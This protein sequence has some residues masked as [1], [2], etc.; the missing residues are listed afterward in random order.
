MT[1]SF[2]PTNIARCT[3]RRSAIRGHAT[4]PPGMSKKT[5]LTAATPADNLLCRKVPAPM[6]TT[7]RLTITAL[8]DAWEF[9]FAYDERIVEAIRNLS[10]RRYLPDRRVWIVPR[11]AYSSRDLREHFRFAACRIAEPI[12]PPDLDL[13]RQSQEFIRCLRRQR[14]SENT[15]RNY[16]HQIDMFVSFVPAGEDPFQKPWI[17][18]YMHHLATVTGYSPSSQNVAINAIRLHMV[19]VLGRQMPILHIRPRRVRTLPTVLGMEEVRDILASNN[20]LKHQTVL[21]LIYSGG[22]RVSEAIDLRQRDID[23]DRNV[24]IIRQSKGNKDRQ[25]PL[26]HHLKDLIGQYLQVYRPQTFLFEG[27]TGGQYTTKSIQKLF[28][29]ACEKAGLQK[30]ASIHTL[31]HSYA[32]HLLEGGTDLRIIQAIL[33]HTSSKTTEIYTHVSTRTIANVQNP[34]DKLHDAPPS[35]GDRYG[36][37]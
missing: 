17:E 33:G 12:E 20:N 6:N 18:E 22:L 28:R 2:Q 16:G 26:A 15:I 3:R 11:G 7:T 25:V 37:R 27:A 29:A 1:F 4:W 21:S 19:K 34:F 36:C 31:R 8:D 24:L 32:T 14:Y 13:D 5:P 35:Q 9:S 30:H 10:Q 23:W